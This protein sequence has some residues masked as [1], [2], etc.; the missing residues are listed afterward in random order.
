MKSEADGNEF[1]YSDLNGKLRSLSV[2]PKYN[3]E[4]ADIFSCGAT[5]FMIQMQ[6][7]PFRK[8]VQTDPYFK[9]LSSAMKQNF[10]KIFK[11]VPF[12]SAF[13]ELSEKTL[14][15]FPGHRFNLDQILGSH[16][17]SGEELMSTESFLE[18]IRTRYEK[19]ELE[20]TNDL[21]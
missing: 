3:G 4:K 8:A 11:N 13:R 21:G 6:S 12:T 15:K 2:Y 1:V 5:L 19:V 14:A 9:R 17:L 18:E 20:K 7:P 16:F 10:W